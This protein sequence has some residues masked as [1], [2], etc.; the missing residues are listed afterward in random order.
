MK[1][2]TVSSFLVRTEE[3]RRVVGGPIDAATQGYVAL[4][5]GA[6]APA[7]ATGPRFEGL[8]D[9]LQRFSSGVSEAVQALSTITDG[10]GQ[11]LHQIAQAYDENESNAQAASQSFFD[12]EL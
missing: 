10:Y 4:S 2:A 8:N 12:R 6:P 5:A 9:A 7:I 3:L 1:G 11:R